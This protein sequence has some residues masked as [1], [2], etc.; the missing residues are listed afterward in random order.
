M[1]KL[2]QSFP[3]KFEVMCIHARKS[4]CNNLSVMNEFKYSNRKIFEQVKSS[5]MT[6]K[7]KC[8]RFSCEAL[9]SSDPQKDEL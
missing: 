3:R 4:Y 8:L 7:F 6:R 1:Q 5:N 2:T 9:E